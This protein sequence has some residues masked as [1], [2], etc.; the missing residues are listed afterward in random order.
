VTHDLRLFIS[1]DL[2]ADDIE[3]IETTNDEQI[4]TRESE[5]IEIEMI[6]ND[7]NI[8]VTMTDVYYYFELNSNLI[9]LDVLKA[10]RFDFLD[11]KN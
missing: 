1:L 5:T 11:R 2:N 10:K 4:K 3:C 9:S 6:V 8:I 7:K